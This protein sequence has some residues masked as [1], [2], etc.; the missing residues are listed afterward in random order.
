[1]MQMFLAALMGGGGNDLLDKARPEEFE[2]S[3]R[4]LLGLTRRPGRTLAMFELPLPPFH[5]QYGTIQRATAEEYG[6]ILIPKRLLAGVIGSRGATQ[7]GLHLSEEGHR[8]LAKI[9]SGL[10]E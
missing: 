9:V 4:M 10:L 8:R 3:L 2:S 1:M 7:D 6:V 5:N